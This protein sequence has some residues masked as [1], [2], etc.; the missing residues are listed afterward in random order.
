MRTSPTTGIAVVV[1]HDPQ[2]YVAV[3]GHV[4]MQTFPEL[5]DR[6]P[7]VFGWLAAHG[8]APAGPPFFRYRV[9][10]MAAELVIEAGVP[11]AQDVTPEADLSVDVLP[12]GRYVTTTYVGPPDHLVEVT[13]GLLRWAEDRRLVFDVSPSPAGEIW[14]C[15]LEWLETNPAEQ[16][17]PSKWQ[18][19]LAFRLAD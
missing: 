7:G 17:D 1:E 5:A 15:R 3:T 4:T 6:L 16:P 2:P 9:I 12:A 19:R 8:V 11:V 18:T 14:G 13:A 10:D